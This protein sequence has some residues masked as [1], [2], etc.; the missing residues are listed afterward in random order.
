MSGIVVLLLTAGIAV[1]AFLLG[2]AAKAANG[3]D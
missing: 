1:G 3:A 2:S